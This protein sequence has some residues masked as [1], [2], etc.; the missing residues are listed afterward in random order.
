MVAVFHWQAPHILLQY[1]PGCCC[2]FIPVLWY[3]VQVLQPQQTWWNSHPDDCLSKCK[4]DIFPPSSHTEVLWNHPMPPPH[5]LSKIASYHPDVFHKLRLTHKNLETPQAPIDRNRSA[6]LQ[7]LLTL[8]TAQRGR[9]MNLEWAI[10][11]T[12]HSEKVSQYLIALSTQSLFI[13]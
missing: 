7:P 10:R 5:G 9:K 6:A 11:N 3:K 4:C 8:H 12:K 13:S 2:Y 1:I